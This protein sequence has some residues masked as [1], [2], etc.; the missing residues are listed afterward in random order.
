MDVRTLND[1]ALLDEL[2]S[3]QQD[4]VSYGTRSPAFCQAA[5]LRVIEGMRELEH[6]YPPAAQSTG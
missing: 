3:A 1:Q 5:W 2:Q 4:V 6:R